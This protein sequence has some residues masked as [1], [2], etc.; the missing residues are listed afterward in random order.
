MLFKSLEDVGGDKFGDTIGVVFGYGLD[1]LR[2]CIKVFLAGHEE[3][4]FDMVIEVA[5]HLGE[6]EFVFEVGYG[7]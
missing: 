1:D 5:V 2:T 3:D 4:G 6:L 7:A